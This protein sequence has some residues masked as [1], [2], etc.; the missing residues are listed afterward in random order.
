MGS[1]VSVE[2]RLLQIRQWRTLL[3]FC[4]SLGMLSVALPFLPGK[5]SHIGFPVQLIVQMPRF[6]DC[7][8]PGAGCSDPLM[9]V[10]APGFA[11]LFAPRF[12]LLFVEA[13]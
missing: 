3:S 9:A 12:A 13:A 8:A 4:R 1:R 7:D 5:G 10:F 11:S 6:D 2:G